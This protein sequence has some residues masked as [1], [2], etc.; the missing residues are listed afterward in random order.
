MYYSDEDK[1]KVN[2]KIEQQSYGD[3]ELLTNPKFT[4]TLLFYEGFVKIYDEGY[5]KTLYVNS[6]IP[7]DKERRKFFFINTMSQESWVL[8]LVKALA[9]YMGSYDMLA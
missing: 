5:P 2:Q 8:L 3:P 9:K 4:E 7:F 6:Y 1:K